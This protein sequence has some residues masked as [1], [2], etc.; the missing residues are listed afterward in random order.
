MRALA[1][2]DVV[3][4][5]GGHVGLGTKLR[6]W[7]GRNVGHFIHEVGGDFAIKGIPRRPDFHGCV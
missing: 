5:H 7:G 2:V 6:D 4:P 3:S 1:A